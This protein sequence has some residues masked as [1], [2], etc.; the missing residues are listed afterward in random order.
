MFEKEYAWQQNELGEYR[1]EAVK[2]KRNIP[3]WVI[4]A[5][6]AVVVSAAALLVYTV[7][8]LP[9]M[10]PSTV[11]SYT[12]G[13]GSEGQ[14]SAPSAPAGG[15]AGLGERLDA[16]VVAIEARSVGGGFFGQ[17]LTN[18]GGSGVVVSADG[19]ILTNSSAIDSRSGTV[20]VRMADGTK[21]DAEVVGT[22]SRTDCAILKIPQTG[23]TPVEFADSDSL[24]SGV[25]VAALGRIL[26]EQLGTTLSEGIICGVSK[27]V[28]LQNGQSVNLVQTDAASPESSG[29]ILINSDGKVVGMITSMISS[30]ADGIAL[31]VP[32]NDIIQVLESVINTGY[33]PQG[34][35]IGIRGTDSDYGVAVEAVSEDSAAA[36]AG[37]KVG[38]LIIKADGTP[39]KSVSEINKIRDTHTAG[40]TMVFT[41]Y[42]DGEMLDI[43]VKLG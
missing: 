4:S 36:K 26:N 33:A 41:I 29:S 40:D 24:T 14:P 17:M 3:A 18:G 9:N 5:A 22:D 27:G 39:V 28:S 42:R 8:I 23:I 16:A 12:E 1:Y 15:F 34:L 11:I 32:S 7:A 30:G 43:N 21:Y 31:A 20:S 35:V 37:M 13:G 10:R 25:Q 19:Y 2:R 38:D 6:V